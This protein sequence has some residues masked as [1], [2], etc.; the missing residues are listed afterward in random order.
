MA[1]DYY[2]GEYVVAVNRLNIRGSASSKHGGN[3]V[4]RQLTQGD[5]VE[6]FEVLT[7]DDGYVWGRITPS[8]VRL[9]QYICLTNWNTIFAKRQS[10][11]DEVVPNATFE[12]LISLYAW[13][14][15]NGYTGPGPV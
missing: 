7:G 1:L 3:L 4:G 13:A 6:I 9:P 10:V 5:T 11:P 15:G 8:G 14:K 12:F 2:P